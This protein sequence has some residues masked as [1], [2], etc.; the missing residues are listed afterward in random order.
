[1]GKPAAR[2]TDMH[3][4]PASDG[5]KP[6]VG[7]PISGPGCPTVLIAGLPAARKGDMCVCV[8]PPDTIA[9]GSTGVMIGGK[10]AA[11]M[12]DQCAHGGTIVI[13]CLT[14]LIGE[15]TLRETMYLSEAQA[16]M[17]SM[18]P[19][20]GTVMPFDY[21]PDCCYS[22]ARTMCDIMEKNGFV[23]KKLWYEGHLHPV[24]KD[25][26][27]VT[28][29]N[30]SYPV[31]WHY[32]VA[33]LMKVQQP[34]GSIQDM[35]LDPSLSERPLTVTEWKRRCNHNPKQGASYDKITDSKTAYPFDTSPLPDDTV[36][37]SKA[38]MEGHARNR[39]R[40]KIY[41]RPIY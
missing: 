36:S 27:G 19:F 39:D 17:D 22:R 1:M 33:P 40:S 4:C 18:D 10:P 2:L 16:F 6:H 37:G 8:G 31:E 15:V 26:S 5:P 24:K 30:P 34:D 14:V 32:H 25:G 21:P 20:K 23:C 41:N 7:G 11:R 35:I 13:G 38:I 9:I 3:V 12:G 29:P 28:F